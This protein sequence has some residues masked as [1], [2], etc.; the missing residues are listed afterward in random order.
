MKAVLV[1]YRISEEEKEKIEALN[2]KVLIVPPYKLLYD[3][4]CGHPDMLLSI[5]DSNT[6]VVH[7]EMD[8]NFVERI[9]KYNYKVLYS[10][11]SLKSIYPSDIIL[12]AVNL[13]NLFIHNLKHTDNVLL[14]NVNYKKI[15]SVSQ[16]YSKCSTAIVSNNAVMTSDTGIAKA[17]SE[18]NIDVLLLPPGDILLPGLNYGFIGGCCGLL[19]KGLVAFYGSL[20]NYLFKDD[21]YKFLKKHKVEPISL[22]KG[23][24]IDRG[25]ILLINN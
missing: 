7:R 15:K 3:A 14:K 5:I 13:E 1:D 12:N 20:N 25:S 22:S 24:L 9:K 4:V 23:Q 17:L 11:N 10:E 2:L 8:L 6:I 16:G 19:E 21:V 18:E